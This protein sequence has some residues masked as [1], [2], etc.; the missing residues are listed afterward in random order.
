MVPETC[1]VFIMQLRLCTV[2]T[3]TIEDAKMSKN[4]RLHLKM[5]QL[6]YAL[7]YLTVSNPG[8]VKGG[9]EGGAEG[10]KPSGTRGA[11]N[12]VALLVGRGGRG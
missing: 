2:V 3:N 6:V 8:G 12:T 7:K 1:T 4:S 11:A 9:R 5:V 10:N